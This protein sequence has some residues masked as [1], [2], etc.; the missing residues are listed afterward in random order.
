MNGRA[1][2]RRT[3]MSLSLALVLSLVS[4]AH[5]RQQWVAPEA[6]V[7]E[8]RPDQIRLTRKDG[9]QLTLRDPAVVRDSLVGTVEKERRAVALT[10]VDHVYVRRGSALLPA[11]LIPLGIVLGLGIAIA[12]TWD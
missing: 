10:D 9:T 3:T 6:V 11:V 2:S 4:C 5:W 7:A 12:A 1:I 8:E